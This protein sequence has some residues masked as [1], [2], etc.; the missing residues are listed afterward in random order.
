MS[1]IDERIVEMKFNNGQFQSGV[2]DTQR[3]LAELKKGLNLDDAASNLNKLDEAGKR[4]NIANIADGVQSIASKFNVL[5]AIGFTVLQNLTNA[6]LGFGKSLV[7]NVLDPLVAGGKRRA[8]NIEQ[9][10]F[11]FQGLG[12]DIEATMAAALY[13]VKGTAFGLDEAAKAAASLGAS[14]VPIEKMGSTLRAI[15]GVAAL[16]GSEY[17]D[18]ADVFTKVA[19]QGRLMGDDLNRLASRGMNAAATLAKAMGVSESE[20][21]D[22]VS[23]NK[24]S[25]EQFAQI[26][27]DAFG[28]QATKASDTY[29]GALANMRAALSRIGAVV[30]TSN[31]ERLRLI[32][33]ALAPQIDAV[34]AAIKPLTD[35]ISELLLNS[36]RS[37]EAWIKSFDFSEISSAMGPA[38]QG[39]RNLLV[40]L[41][42]ILTPLK[43][44][45]KEI[46]PKSAAGD[47]TNL[48]IRFQAF[49]ERLRLG[50]ET[51]A[52]IKS[53]FRGFFAF[54]DIGRLILVGFI[55]ML[56]SLF[57]NLDVGGA[58]FLNITAN[59]GEW[60]VSVRDALRD[61]EGLSN[62]F[63]TLGT[64]LSVPLGLLGA[65]GKLLVSVFDA[66][67][68]ADF[69]KLDFSGFG[70]AVENIKKRFSEIDFSSFFDGLASGFANVGKRF[71][72]FGKIGDN[73]VAA[74]GHVKD[75]FAGVGDFFAP[76]VDAVKNAA[77]NI[78]EAFKTSFSTGEF[79]TVLDAINT[80]LFGAIV[81]LIKN[82]LNGGLDGLLNGTDT[83]S[84]MEN[85]QGIFDGL[86]DTM[87]AMQTKLKAETLL[88]IAFAIGI[89][90]ASVILLSLINPERLASALLAIGILF[91]YMS[92]AMDKFAESA[93]SPGLAKLPIVAAGFIVLGIAVLIL[94]S[95]VK[96]LADLDWNELAKGLVGVA[97]IMG[98]MVG[99]AKLLEK[100]APMMISSGIAMVIF[101]A[102]IKIMASAVKDFSDLSWEEIGKG[103]VGVGTMLGGLALFNKFAKIGPASGI[104]AIGILALAG[105]LKVLASATKDFSD[106]EWDEMTRGMVGIGGGLA[107]VGLAMK[108]MPK[109]L[110]VSAVGLTIT[111][112][113]LLIL[114]KALKEMGS[115]GWDEI[116]KAGVVLLGSLALIAAG[117][118]AMTGGLPG[119]AA[120]VVAS[121]AL[122]VL[123]QAL[124]E[125]GKLG[126]EE[127]GKV[128]V[129]LFGALTILALGLTAMVAA[130]PGAAALVVAAAALAILVPVLALMGGLAWDVIG[131]GLLGLAAA[132][133]ILA[134]GGILLLPAIPGLIALGVAILAIGA[135][136][137]LASIGI[138]LLAGAITILIAAGSGLP[139]M[140][141][142]VIQAVLSQIPYAMEQ[143]ALGI[144][145]FANVISTSGTSMTAAFTAIIQS[146]LDSINT[147][148]PQIIDTMFS[149]LLQLADKIEENMPLLVEKGGNIIISFLRG[150]AAKVPGIASAA[151]DLIIA[152]IRAIGQNSARIGEAGM[153]TILTFI[154]SLTRS[155]N[156]YAP[157]MRSAGLQLAIAIVDGMTG[158]LF[159]GASR[160]ISAAGEMAGRALAKAR[161][162]LDINSPSKA[163]RKLG[164]SSAEGFGDGIVRT[165]PYSTEAANRMGKDAL[166]A[167]SSTLGNFGEDV[168]GAM[169]VDPT[170]RPVLDLS[171]IKK[172]SSLINGMLPNP[173]LNTTKPA[174]QATSI[175]RDYTA[176]QVEAKLAVAQQPS[177]TNVELKQYNSSPKA[178]SQIDIYRNTHNQLTAAKG[179]LQ[180]KP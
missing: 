28:A 85:I 122:V 65:L 139:T 179:A 92:L 151:T 37:M 43:E 125:M 15:S 91:A 154:Q 21:R 166:N 169:D 114:S 35:L 152:F 36:G 31:F 161:E 64:V 94:A 75:F 146:F 48:M 82:F 163:F 86:T 142:S 134:V 128:M 95:A 66:V 80:G 148:S 165:T 118:Y 88:K 1:S 106:M 56:G 29:T 159:S 27:D 49:T 68:N 11:Q 137:Y 157:Q 168:A 178:L 96:K 54:I 46:I 44:A 10:K 76:M 130:L 39:I 62:F 26:M 121:A 103:L 33:N 41:G 111:A 67:K 117:L 12:L 69:S 93:A 175:Q 97:A 99:A 98:M 57:G 70:D 81:L 8:L 89:L 16:T 20:V 14:Q 116:A 19:G 171:G 53:T 79:S 55:K 102:G 59:L 172:D 7:A 23:K 24:I 119:A 180:K 2:K 132:L 127:I 52:K 133:A 61:G 83:T 63:A 160:V 112:A 120:L 100:S 72:F 153:Q 58:G 6:A 149:L 108:L 170:I 77:V 50:D 158:G 105:A 18:V 47:L 156:Q 5:G 13:A 90:A 150:M 38:V 32:F 176:A 123:A 129:I 22:M 45:F 104:Q 131:T 115:M 141:T 144:V 109:N 34:A 3:A 110:A 40:V 73:L 138:V 51:V 167:I 124:K 174:M 155:V 140:I 135:G 4:F 113:A 78:W 74:W 101:A 145:A 147:L 9:A 107:I 136:V 71:E 173:S 126:W 162:V 30:A 164:D 42:Q 87:E 17:A 84:F 60:I 177:V 143:F 25:F